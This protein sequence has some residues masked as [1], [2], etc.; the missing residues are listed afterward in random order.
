M[1]PEAFFFFFLNSFVINVQ[2]PAQLD[3]PLG[4]L[5]LGSFKYSGFSRKAHLSHPLTEPWG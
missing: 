2:V 5:S 4:Q 1:R 3:L